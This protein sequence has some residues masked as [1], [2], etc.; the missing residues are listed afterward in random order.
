MICSGECSRLHKEEIN[1]FT[2]EWRR[3]YNEELNNIHW[4]M[5]EIA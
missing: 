2:G 4:G 3:L 5:E 1:D